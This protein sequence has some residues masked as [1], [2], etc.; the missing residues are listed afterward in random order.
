MGLGDNV[1]LVLSLA[2]FVL[3]VWGALIVL[4][5]VKAPGVQG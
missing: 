1:K 4:K 3:L 2:V 5:K